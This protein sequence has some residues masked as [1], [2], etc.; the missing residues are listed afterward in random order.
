MGLQELSYFLLQVA[1]PS[2]SRLH[3]RVQHI[4]HY[5]LTLEFLV[6]SQSGYFHTLSQFMDLVYVTFLLGMRLQP[7]LLLHLNLVNYNI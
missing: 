7:S 3:L 5:L 6:E 1:Q 4:N 2:L